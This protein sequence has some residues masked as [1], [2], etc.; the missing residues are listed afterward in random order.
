MTP[1]GEEEPSLVFE[2]ARLK[3]HHLDY[4]DAAFILE[5]LNEPSFIQFI[6][7]KGVR[8][9]DDAREYLQNGPLDSYKRHG[10]GLFR[11]VHR[12]DKLAVGICGLLQ[13]D[14]LADPDIGFA[15]LP[16][17]WSKG[18]AQEAAAA[19]L[20]HGRDQLNMKRVVAIT[21]RDNH[22]SIKL[23]QKIGLFFEG[24][25]RLADDADEVNLY[26]I[27]FP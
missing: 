2:T 20:D 1:G 12:E 26:A 10:F 15:F 13:R 23:L 25:V 21:N 24:T 5:L 22:S 9:L 7:D 18:F 19:T 17:F 14:E 27:N 4:V 11:V 16:R 6:G 8:T 3:L